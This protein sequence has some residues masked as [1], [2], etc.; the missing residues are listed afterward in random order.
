MGLA[1]AQAGKG[2]LVLA[3]VTRS[4]GELALDD[5]PE[6]G[7]P[8]PG[9]VIVRP[10]VVGICGSDIHLFTGDV[11]ALS[12]ARGF[13]PRIQGHELC[14]VV[15]EV[16]VNCPPGLA[17]GD[18]VAIWPLLPC[19]RCY[20][21]RS[22]RPNACVSLQLVGIHRDGGL[23]ERLEVPA[24]QLVGVGDL[25]PSYG[26]F[27]EPVSIAVHA[28]RRGGLLLA[29]DTRTATGHPEW[30]VLVFGAGPIGLATVLAATDAG[31][32]V[33]VLDPV[34]SRRDLASATGAE[35]AVWGTRDEILAAAAEWTGGEGPPLVFDTTGEPGVLPDAVE[36]VSSAG[37]VV[38]VGM[39]AA[40]AP[41]RP[42]V[43]PEKEIDV[44]GSS[45]ATAGDFA[46]AVRL[47]S[48]N[49]K[50]VTTMLTHRFPLTRTRE[51][52]EFVMSRPPDAV[53]VLV[54]VAD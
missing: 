23:Q 15:D 6:P 25:D 33:M 45:C 51:A 40:T 14:A 21:C 52:V 9:H 3:A 54:T 50:A 5:V 41:L 22:G 46:A 44:T 49:Q 20:P 35:R 42:G 28:I 10:E 27:V 11:A 37:R 43:F 48:G 17:A 26:A 18:R 38:V 13:Y 47:V 8:S 39:S 34:P 24:T 16:G 32:R 19:A 12:G 30:Q 7:P 29:A 31:A 36:M 1:A 2:P 4:P 53:K